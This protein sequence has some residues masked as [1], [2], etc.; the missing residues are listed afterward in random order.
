[1]RALSNQTKLLNKNDDRLWYPH[2]CEA[3]ILWMD[4]EYFGQ[5]EIRLQSQE[6]ASK[7]AFEL[8]LLATHT[9]K[10]ALKPTWP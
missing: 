8:R 6:K 10:T 5:Y 9:N 7:W 1:M 4:E 3:A 2:I